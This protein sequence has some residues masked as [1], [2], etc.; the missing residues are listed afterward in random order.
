LLSAL[1][2]LI[3]IGFF[4]AVTTVF[5][6]SYGRLL[7]VSGLDRRLPAIISKVNTNRVPWVAPLA[8]T[9]IGISFTAIIFILAPL[10]LNSAEL[11]TLMFDILNASMTVIWCVSMVILFIDVIII[12]SKYQGTFSRIQLV[13]NWLFYLCSIVGSLASIAGVYVIFTSPWTNS[14]AMKPLTTLQWDAWIAGITIISLI[15]AV[16]GFYIGRTTLKSD[17]SDEDIIAEVTN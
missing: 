2:D 13:P 11:T 9:I 15:V 6:Y 8:Q 16:A 17:L 12:S 5:N 7:F 10:S 1:L 4:I 3:L 14:P